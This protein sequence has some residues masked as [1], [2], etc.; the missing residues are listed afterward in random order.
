MGYAIRTDRIR[1]I[2]WRDRATHELVDTELYEHANDADENTNVAT[3]NE[4]QAVVAELSGWI[5][6]SF[7]S[8]RK[9]P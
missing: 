3:R 2:E 1:Y 8:L 6:A 5:Q 4:H 9:E 7:D